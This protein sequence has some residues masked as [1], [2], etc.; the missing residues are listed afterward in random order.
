[1]AG[2]PWRQPSSGGRGLCDD[3]EDIALFHNGEF[4]AIYFDFGTGPLAEQ[5]AITCL[6]VKRRKLAAVIAHTWPHSNNFP[7]HRLF[8]SRIG[9]DD[10]A[11]GF[12]VVFDAPHDNPVVKRAEFHG[13]IQCLTMEFPPS[14]CRQ[15]CTAGSLANLPLAIF[16]NLSS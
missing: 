15:V 6:Y 14:P 16:G 5:D 9:N 11:F 4:F 10:A 12:R 2:T 13:F 3:P 7:L 8:L 1:M